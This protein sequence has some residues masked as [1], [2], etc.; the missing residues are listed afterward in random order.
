ME[1]L[2]TKL[3]LALTRA[4]DES[5]TEETSSDVAVLDKARHLSEFLSRVGDVLSSWDSTLAV[6]FRLSK[7]LSAVV[8]LTF[9]ESES[10]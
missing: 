4:V 10:I 8:L 6:C 3:S 9:E 5:V 1:N 2:G 7:V